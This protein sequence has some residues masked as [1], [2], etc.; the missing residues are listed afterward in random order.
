M[1]IYKAALL[2]CF[3]S[4]KVVIVDP[5]QV[6]YTSKDEELKRVSVAPLRLFATLGRRIFVVECLS[7]SGLKREL[8]TRNGGG[9]VDVGSGHRHTLRYL[10]KSKV[11]EVIAV[12]TNE[13]MWKYIKDEAGKVGIVTREGVLKDCCDGVGVAGENSV[14][15][16]VCVL[17]L[18][19]VRSDNLE[20]YCKNGNCLVIGHVRSKYKQ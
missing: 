4:R 20:K 17:T 9:V 11:N 3:E 15:T 8:I 5:E 13:E 10:D 6:I 14:D 19:S 12:E 16:V 1:S 2:S 18:I 7:K